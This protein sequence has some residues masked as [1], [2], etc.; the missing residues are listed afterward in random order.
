M[1]DD[2]YDE[3]SMSHDEAAPS[4]VGK[5]KSADIMF[6]PRTSHYSVVDFVL[7]K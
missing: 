6:K 1:D 4:Q 5:W 7:F 3:Q 2:E